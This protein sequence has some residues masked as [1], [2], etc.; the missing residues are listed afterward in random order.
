M[1]SRFH[2]PEHRRRLVFASSV[3]A[4]ALAVIPLAHGLAA[5]G[6]EEANQEPLG[7]EEQTLQTTR[8]HNPGMTPADSA[9][10]AA[11]Q[12][13]RMDMM[14]KFASEFHGEI[15]GSWL[16]LN[17]T[18]LVI[19]TTTERAGNRARELAREYGIEV[20]IE[21][22]KRSMEALDRRAAMVAPG[23][24]PVIGELASGWVE[25]DTQGNVIRLGVV[26][27]RMAEAQSR[28]D[29]ALRRGVPEA[30]GVVLVETPQGWPGEPD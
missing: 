11:E 26:P 5:V 8:E 28:L 9:R 16:P 21:I 30:D 25:G 19:G 23:R 10:R 22:M 15:A 14:Q 3:V 27:G 17:S 20:R 4:A 18:V 7:M 1:S 2:L 12:P 29:D 13:R 24:D 6:S